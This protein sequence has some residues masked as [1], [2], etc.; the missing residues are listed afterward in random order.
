MPGPQPFRHQGAAT[1]DL[2]ADQFG[3]AHRLVIG[4]VIGRAG[5][6]A[7]QRGDRRRVVVDIPPGLH[8]AAADHR[9]A[10]PAQA[11]DQRVTGRTRSV[12]Q[13]MTQRDPLNVRPVE[14]LLLA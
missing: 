11:V 5:G 4:D 13:A 6:A 10:P 12:E 14:H 2:S 3:K 9:K 7:F 8:P 1:G